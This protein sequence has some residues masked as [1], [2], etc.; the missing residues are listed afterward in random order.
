M[1]SIF[2]L[3]FSE[4]KVALILQN[5]LKKKDGYSLYIPLSRQQEGVDLIIHNLKTKKTLTIQIKSS[6]S[7]E[8]I[9]SKRNNR[10]VHQHSSWFNNF[11]YKYKE[12]IADYYVFFTPYPILSRGNGIKL[13][14]T[15]PDKWWGFKSL[16]FSDNEMGTLLNEIKT[17]KGKVESKFG[18]G[19]DEEN[20]SIYLTRGSDRPVLYTNNLLENKISE[21]KQKLQ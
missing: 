7:Y 2:T 19:F 9:P 20:D 4:Y 11:L 10:I 8:G 1:D 3:P 16:L 21:L 13:D 6:R 14:K 17:K 5:E 15:T 18:F 12:G